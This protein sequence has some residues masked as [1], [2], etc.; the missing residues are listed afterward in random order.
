MKVSVIIPVYNAGKYVEDAVNSALRQKEV[1]EIILVEDGSSDNSLGVCK[2][3]EKDLKKIKLFRH[4]NGENRGAGETRNLGLKKATQNYIA[5]LDADDFYLDNRFEKTKEVF[6]TNRKAD[7][8][9]EAIGI[10]FE[11]K[12]SKGKWKKRSV[13]KITTLVEEVPP[14]ELFKFLV[15]A[16]RGHFHL[17]GLTIKREVLDKELGLFNK[18]LKI[19]QDT[20]FCLKLALCK[21][22]CPGNIKK[23]IAKRRAHGENRITKVDSNKM[24]GY[25]KILWRSL[26]DQFRN[27]KI[28]FSNKAL[29]FFMDYYYFKLEKIT[30]KKNKIRSNFYYIPFLT[31]FFLKKPLQ[32]FSVF[33]NTLKYT[34][35]RFF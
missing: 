21:K 18:N 7:G 25:Q 3:L 32:G 20:H 4:P 5:F 12:K 10:H 23:P 22:L 1:K 35:K 11:D 15:L 17:D 19:S 14:E 29:I 2:K 16:G 33:L 13:K 8:I 26:K 6:K 9:Y 27:K 28:G 30:K 24:I 34:V 31:L